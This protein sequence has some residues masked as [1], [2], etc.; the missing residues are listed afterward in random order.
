VRTNSTVKGQDVHDGEEMM[1][2]V[3]ETPSDPNV[4]TAEFDPG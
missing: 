3:V 4:K 2:S 1:D